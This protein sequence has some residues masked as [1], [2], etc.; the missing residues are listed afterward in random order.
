MSQDV[1]DYMLAKNIA[2]L[3]NIYATELTENIIFH[4][5]GDGISIAKSKYDSFFHIV[6]V[7]SFLL[8]KDFVNESIDSV[9]YYF[10]DSKIYLFL[11]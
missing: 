6:K 3:L 8:A 2:L 9:A 1:F 10:E 7:D 5:V 11:R 4:K